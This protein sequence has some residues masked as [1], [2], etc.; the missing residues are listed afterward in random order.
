[1]NVVCIHQ[2]LDGWSAPY[3]SRIQQ[4]IHPPNLINQISP[5]TRPSAPKAFYNDD[6]TLAAGKGNVGAIVGGVV[7]GVVAVLA[8][9]A[10]LFALM[11][12]KR[13]RE[14]EEIEAAFEAKLSSTGGEA[15]ARD[16]QQTHTGS[17]HAHAESVLK[18]NT[19][20]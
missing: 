6:G 9:L 5:P 12:V 10:G 7:G 11:I 3:L 2:H 1:M 18:P 20:V 13:R 4:S 19:S 8:G 14:L 16:A 17:A 15:A